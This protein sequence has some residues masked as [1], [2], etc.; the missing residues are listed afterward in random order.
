M[1]LAEEAER[2]FGLIPSEFIFW[3]KICHTLT[4]QRQR[5]LLQNS[6]RPQ[7]KEWVG[8]FLTPESEDPEIIYQRQDISKGLLI[9][10]VQQLRLKNQHQFY[11]ILQQSQILVAVPAC[12]EARLGEI[13][14]QGQA[15]RVRVLSIEHGPMKK[16]ILLYYDKIRDL[17]WDPARLQ[18]PKKQE[19]VHYTA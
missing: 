8:F 18:W 4:Q 10:T 5:L 19:F 13:Q 15:P 7:G 3:A 14:Y 12:R 1:C 9:P 17:R 16:Q 6:Q 2:R 11:K